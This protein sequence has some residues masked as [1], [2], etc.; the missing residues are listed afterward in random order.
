[1]FRI[2]VVELAFTCGL[3]LPVLLIPIIITRF[4]ERLGQRLKILKKD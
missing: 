3:L 2:G 4:Y 1:M